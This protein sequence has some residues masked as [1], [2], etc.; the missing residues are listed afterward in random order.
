[1]PRNIGDSLLTTPEPSD[2][3]PAKATACEKKSGSS[4]WSGSG[5]TNTSDNMA[6]VG[7]RSVNGVNHE[8]NDPAAAV[9]IQRNTHLPANDAWDS[10][11]WDLNTQQPHGGQEW[12]E[13]GSKFVEDFS[14]TTNFKGL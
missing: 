6:V 5:T 8:S 12:S 7:M 4:I 3:Q 13:L 14:V 2:E 10:T 11:N 1:M 9:K